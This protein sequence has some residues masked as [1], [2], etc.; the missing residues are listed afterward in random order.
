MI[1]DEA[2]LKPHQVTRLGAESAAASGLSA[3]AAPETF[4]VAIDLQVDTRPRFVSH[5]GQLRFIG[6]F[7]GFTYDD[8]LQL[9]DRLY[10]TA[11]GAMR[12]ESIEAW[13]D[14]EPVHYEVGLVP[15]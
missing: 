1:L 11:H 14:E 3:P 4:T 13:E 6:G 10:E 9:G 15:A 5:D 2:R 8:R 12:V 7:L